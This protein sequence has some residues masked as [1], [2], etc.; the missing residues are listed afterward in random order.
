[1]DWALCTT[2][3]VERI[4]AILKDTTQDIKVVYAAFEAYLDTA[5]DEDGY[6][7]MV[8]IRLQLSGMIETDD[9]LI[10]RLDHI[11]NQGSQSGTYLKAMQ[12]IFGYFEKE[13]KKLPVPSL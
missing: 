11:A 8:Q 9:G 7:L 1:M 5:S 4:I 3:D 10:R 6:F 12:R 13:D 2:P